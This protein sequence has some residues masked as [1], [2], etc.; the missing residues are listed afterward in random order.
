MLFLRAAVAAL[1]VS[2]LSLK[3]TTCRSPGE[4]GKDPAPSPAQN[5][6]V[7]LPGVDTSALTAREKSSWSSYVSELLA[8]CPDQPVSLAQCVK[9]SRPCKSCL[10]AARFLVKEVQDGKTRS[11]AEAAFRTRF[12]PDSVKTIPVGDSPWKGSPDAPIVI[13]EW[14]DFECPFCASASPALD[15]K[16]KQFPGAIK[17]VFKNYPLPA[18][19]NAELAARASMAAKLQGK[20]WEM[21]RALFEQHGKLDEATIRRIAQTIGLDMKR[22]N[23]D[24]SSEAVA[25]AVAADRKQANAIGLEGT[26]TIYINGRLFDLNQFDLEPDM[27]EWIRLELE[28]LGARPAGGA[29]TSSDAPAAPAG[30]AGSPAASAK[31]APAPKSAPPQKP[32]SGAPAP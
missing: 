15:A 29:L 21:H 17:L 30:S 20:F 3:L 25:D 12:A 32:T 10:P 13:V 4:A 23:E 14:A 16:V 5:P 27:D 1:V 7:E 26:P 31:A 11:Q 22:F 18:H 2:S 6:V 8:P 28:L 9:E 19:K 24:V